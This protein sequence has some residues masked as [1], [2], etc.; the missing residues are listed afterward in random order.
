MTVHLRI[1]GSPRLDAPD[2]GKRDA[3]V[4]QS[5]RMALLVY[6]AA[7]VPRGF[8]RRDTLLAL[9]WPELDSTHARAALNQALYV[10]RHA[11]GDGAIL[12]R[13]DGEVAVDPRV[14]WC[15]ARELEAQLDAGNAAEALRL[16]RGD[17]L[18]GFFVPDAPGFEQWVE[19]ERARLRQRAAEGAWIIAEEKATAGDAVEA[20]RWARRATE[21]LPDDEAGVRRLLTFLRR[22]G[23]RSAALRAYE[24]FAWRL[25][26]DYE[27][28]PS[29][30]T[31][32]LAIAI[33]EEGR[34]AASVRMVTLSSLPAILVAVRRTHPAGLIAI[35]LLMVAVLAAARVMRRDNR[36]V[37]ATI[38]F[39]LSFPHAA[40]I[41]GGVTGSTIAMAPDGRT[42]AFLGAAEGGRALLLRRLDQLDAREVAHTNG[43]YLPFFSPKGGRL[44]FVA[45]GELRTVAVAGGSA[46]TVCPVSETVAGASWDA[47]DSIVFATARGVWRVAASG[48]TPRLV[49]A[50]DPGRGESYRWPAVLPGARSVIVTHVASAGFELVAISLEDGGVRPLGVPGTNAHY[51]APNH[52]VFARHDGALLAAPFDARRVAIT[53]PPVPVADGIIVGMHG[54]A[55]LGMSHD[56]A[57]AY[58]PE[59]DDSRSLV[60]VDRTGR[61]MPLAT[62]PQRYHGVRYSRDGA[63][64]ALSILTRGGQ[65]VWVADVAG[66]TVSRLT[67]DQSSVSPEWSP[68]DRRVVFATPAGGREPG[69]SIRSVTGDGGDSATTTLLPAEYGQL[70]LGFAPDQSLLVQ[71]VAA[72]TRRDIWVLG[73]AEGRGKLDPWLRTEADERAAAVSPDGRWVAY[74]SDESGRDEVYIRSFPRPGAPL[75]VS[76]NGGSE[77][78]WART[79]QELFYRGEGRLLAATLNLQ[80]AR[81]LRRAALF[82]DTPFVAIRD[83]AAYDV[84]PDG[85]SFLMIRRGPQRR[86]VVVVLHLFDSLRVAGGRE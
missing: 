68:D 80:E 78:R 59:A 12:T 16:Y 25:G 74:T 58:M 56:G 23:D 30:E 76:A 11:L 63:R 13:G 18:Q 67:S 82:D 15:D 17:L 65:N 1:F 43:A 60:S 7:A 48:G 73:G 14:V 42:M 31:E 61:A 40:P 21:F 27:V 44:G 5:K 28:Q 19:S 51:L 52:L 75:R 81:V 26:R 47:S 84:H 35:G 71:R 55:K 38:R 29:A 34:H 70:A 86:E 54:A 41:A 46:V 10:L 49:A 9:F 57:L 8:H 64:V 79:G 62:P 50:A 32:A 72:R 37:P 6:L 45:Q 83:A 36:V 22:I 3:L 20:G 24:A 77:P 85:R 2:G 39:A 66:A 53:G 4:R 69:F 33:R